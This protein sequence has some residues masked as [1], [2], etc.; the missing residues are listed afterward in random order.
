MDITL[1]SI[2]CSAIIILIAVV[3]GFKQVLDAIKQSNTENRK[4]EETFQNIFS[5]NQEKLVTLI[6]NKSNEIITKFVAEVHQNLEQNI[7]NFTEIKSLVK[8]ATSSLETSLKTYTTTIEKEITK[9]SATLIKQNEQIKDFT[10]DSL[11]KAK[12]ELTKE[13]SE[14]S[15]ENTNNIQKYSQNQERNNINLQTKL[16]NNFS[17]MVQLV[18]NLRLDNLINVSNEIGKYKEGIYEDDHFLQEVGHCKIIKITDKSS[19]E[20]T[21]VYYD[22]NG[23]KSHTE[24]F[25]KDIL[26]YMMKYQNG[27]LKNGIE[28]YKNGEIL[29]EYIY[30]DAEEVSKKIEYIYDEKAQL[31]EKKETNY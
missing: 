7:G 4:G 23:E 27:K 17:N 31:K 28:F 2:I 3:I 25:D 5:E 12:D 16:S 29:F 22:E 19:N 11:I 26:K 20:I 6:E 21:N 10:Y 30:D 8:T 13:L 15:K 1:I 24:T 9:S 18:N 14:F